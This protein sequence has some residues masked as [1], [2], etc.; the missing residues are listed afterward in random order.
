M[1]H[2]GRLNEAVVLSRRALAGY[3]SNLGGKHVLHTDTVNGSLWIEDCRPPVGAEAI[4]RARRASDGK[5]ETIHPTTFVGRKGWLKQGWRA[6]TKNCLSYPCSSA[7]Q[8]QFDT[9]DSIINLKDSV[10]TSLIILV[11]RSIPELSS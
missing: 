5:V 1:R 6:W 10:T 9:Y 4:E 11:F 8:P 7:A 2:M 3:K